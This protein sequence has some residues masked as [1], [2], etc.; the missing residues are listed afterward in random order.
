MQDNDNTELGL[1]VSHNKTS[2]LLQL[3]ESLEDRQDEPIC[4]GTSLHYS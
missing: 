4:L 1:S 3:V 2:R